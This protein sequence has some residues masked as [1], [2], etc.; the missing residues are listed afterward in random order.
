MIW[1]HDDEDWAAITAGPAG[2]RLVPRLRK[3]DMLELGLSSQ[4]R[5]C[6]ASEGEDGTISRALPVPFEPAV[7]D[8]GVESMSRI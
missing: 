6:R 4:C 1:R 8:P 2:R 5:D 3:A 7:Q